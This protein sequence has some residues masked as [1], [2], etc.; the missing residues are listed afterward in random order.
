M[1]PSDQSELARGRVDA[2]ATSLGHSVFDGLYR[3]RPDALARGLG[4]KLLLFFGEGIDAFTRRASRFPDHDEFREARHY[5]DPVLR[6]LPV[7]E[8]DKL[9]NH[10][11]HVLS[12]NTVAHRLRDL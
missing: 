5:K 6:Q 4:C 12:Q 8:S 3:S 7:A 11:I 2:I 9:R 1:P 10:L